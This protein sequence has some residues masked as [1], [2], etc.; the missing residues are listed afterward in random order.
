MGGLET[1]AVLC[2]QGPPA[3]LTG[4]MEDPIGYPG[5]LLRC[6]CI[7]LSGAKGEDRVLVQ[8][9]ARYVTSVLSSANV[10]GKS[11]LYLQCPAVDCCAWQVLKHVQVARFFVALY[12]MGPDLPSL[13]TLL[14][15][16]ANGPS[17]SEAPC[18]VKTWAGC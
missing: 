3:L 8:A 13:L 1:A 16:Q 2:K 11:L 10:S 6:C 4:V 5:I 17:S 15:M 12:P 14:A 9:L 7:P 18:M